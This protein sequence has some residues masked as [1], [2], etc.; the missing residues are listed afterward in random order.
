M[1]YDHSIKWEAFK[2][3]KIVQKNLFLLLAESID[4]SYIIGEEEIGAH[5]FAEVI[6]S[7][8][9]KMKNIGE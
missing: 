5:E 9:G 3:Y 4:Q 6:A 1:Y 2:G 8:D 7:I